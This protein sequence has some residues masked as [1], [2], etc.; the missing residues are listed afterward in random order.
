[1]NI[2]LV[3]MQHHVTLK[4]AFV[5]NFSMRVMKRYPLSFRHDALFLMFFEILVLYFSTATLGKK[6]AYF[7]V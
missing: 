1:M 2:K 4:R 3:A 7:L 6:T 5:I